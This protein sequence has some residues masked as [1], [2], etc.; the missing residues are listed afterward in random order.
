MLSANAF[1]QDF[2]LSATAGYL[3]LNS[4]FKVNG[5]KRDLD[6]K[7][8]GF[9]LGAQT[10]IALAEKIDLQP[11]LLLGINSEGNTMYLG[12]LASY[13]ITDEFSVLAGPSFNYLLEDVFSDYQKFGVFASLGASYDFTETI[14]AQ[15]KYGFQL[16]DFYTGNG[17]VSSKINFLLIGIGYKIL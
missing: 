12:A 10:K 17:D 1:A 16:N 5:E 11:E 3:N 13:E 6:F 15:A 4:I 9:Y 8:S 14:Y 2:N 7:S